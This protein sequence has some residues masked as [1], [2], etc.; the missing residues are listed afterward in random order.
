MQSY[1]IEFHVLTVVEYGRF[2]FQADVFRNVKVGKFCIYIRIDNGQQ[3]YPDDT[4]Y[5]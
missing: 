2:H 3:V 4:E 1:G 5:T